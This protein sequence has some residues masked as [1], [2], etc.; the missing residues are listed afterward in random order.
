MLGLIFTVQYAAEYAQRQQGEGPRLTL[1]SLRDELIVSDPT[2]FY[3]PTPFD[4]SSRPQSSLVACLFP[5]S[6]EFMKLHNHSLSLSLRLPLPPAP[7]SPRP[8][9]CSRSFSSDSTFSS[10]TATLLLVTHGPAEAV[11]RP[12]AGI[13]ARQPGRHLHHGHWRESA[14]NHL[15][16]LP[17][18][19]SCHLNATNPTHRDGNVDIPYHIELTS[20]VPVPIISL[21]LFYFYC[22]LDLMLEDRI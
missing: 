6:N 9:R 14:D 12:P 22:R 15:P 19:F 11:C 1:Q 20:L 7:L 5:H 3:P 4:S 10:L 21:L 8:Y 17:L 16:V 2:P 18:L 13:P